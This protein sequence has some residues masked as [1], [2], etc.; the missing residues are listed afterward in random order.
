[1]IS[2]QLCALFLL[3]IL[4]QFHVVHTLIIVGGEFKTNVNT[5]EDCISFF[6]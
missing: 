4:S 1:M 5:G 2:L 6:F 3:D